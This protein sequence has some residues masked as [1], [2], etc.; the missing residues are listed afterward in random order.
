MISITDY[1][2][3]SSA[4]A[5]ALDLATVKDYLKVPR[6]LSADDSLIIAMTETASSIFEKVTGRNL[7]NKTWKTYLDNFPSR[8][9]LYY[10]SGVS[11][12]IPQYNDNGIKLRKSKLQSITHIKYYIDGVLTTFPN[13][14]YYF[15][16]LPDY[17][18]I[19]LVD[20][21]SFPR[22]DS[23][24]QAIVITFISGFGSATCDIPIDIQNALLTAISY[25]YE[26][27]GDCPNMK[28]M[29]AST[30]IFDQYKVIDF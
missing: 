23:R 14:D 19:Y 17:S 29:V 16:D 30:Q 8:N 2:L 5:P 28:D 20:G 9:S 22:V 13:T 3:L 21:K 15:T 6:S 4:A 27:R 24:K 12:L 25:Q 1:T 26:N 10:Y 11:N 18:S 7:I